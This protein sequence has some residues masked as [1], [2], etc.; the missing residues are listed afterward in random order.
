MWDQTAISARSWRIHSPTRFCCCLNGSATNFRR[1]PP[2]LLGLFS[3]HLLICNNSNANERLIDSV[4][5]LSHILGPI[6]TLKSSDKNDFIEGE[7]LAWFCYLF[8]SNFRHNY[9]VCCGHTILSFEFVK[10]LIGDWA[11]T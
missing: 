9:S 5:K 3:V 7:L 8:S 6:S 11:I 4:I 2:S 1:P 10:V